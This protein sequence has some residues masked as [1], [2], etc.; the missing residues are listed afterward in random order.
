MAQISLDTPVQ[1]VKGVGPAR[2]G[3]LGKL[4]IET[5]EDLL[6][7]FPFRFDLR[8]Q[9]QPMETVKGGEQAITVA[10]QVAAIEDRR[11]GKT[12]FF[13]CELTDGTAFVFVKWFH[14]G[15]LRDKIKV[16]LHLAISGKVSVFKEYPQFINPRFQILWDP[17]DSDLSRDEMLPVYPAGAKLS[18]AHIGAII[19]KVLP[20]TGHLITEWFR[21]EFLR[22]RG[23]MP[24]DA[25]VAAMHNPEDKGHWSTARK[26]LAYEECL[27]M[28]LGIAILRMHQIS[29]PARSLI[30]TK[31]IDERIRA[32]FPFTLTEAQNQ[33][34][35]E[36][37]ADLAKDRPM[38]RLLQGD[39]GSG[40]TVVAL[41]AALL[42][43][44]RGFQVAIMAPTEILATQHYNKIK[45]YLDGSQVR[46]E[47]FLG[48]QP[49]K[50]R[51]RLLDGLAKGNIH[52]AVGTHALLSDKI[53]FSR[54][55]L[56]VVDEQH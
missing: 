31:Q 34:V 38:N 15:Y 47:L 19:R 23:L 4:G 26:R 14:G 16:G 27:L 6:M 36:I 17:D 44:A 13:Q 8:K 40:K 49:A 48:G 37:S 28:Q 55:G 41:H 7:Y 45:T 33:A 32:R 2:A 9:V 11:Y 39:V 43:V 24:R 5:V 12:P 50:K 30:L 10:G 20:Q 18:S 3:Q 53:A 46:T 35:T 42:T 51:K 25:A 1:Y 56:V 54:L 52:I 21:P 22:R 29:R